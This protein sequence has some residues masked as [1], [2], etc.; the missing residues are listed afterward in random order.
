MVPS[1]P[2][3]DEYRWGRRKEKYINII[4]KQGLRNINFVIYYKN[5]KR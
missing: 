5:W 3:S 1:T 4:V 2:K